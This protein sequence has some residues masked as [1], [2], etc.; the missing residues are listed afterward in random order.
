MSSNLDLLNNLQDCSPK[1]AW[2]SIFDFAW[3]T[4]SAEFPSPNVNAE[5][6]K[7]DKAI[8]EVDHFLTTAGWDLWDSYGSDAPSTSKE[9]PKWWKSNSSGRAILVLDALSLRESSW[10]LVG[11][12]KR[13]YKIHRSCATGAELPADTTPFAKALGFSQRSSLQ[14][15]QA[16]NAHKFS[17]AKTESVGIA[18]EDC[19]ELI[20]ADPDIFF[21]HQWPDDLIHEHGEPGSGRGLSTMVKETESHL[22][23]D[24]FW[25]FIERLSKGRRLVITADHGYA[26]SELFPDAERE[27]KEYLKATF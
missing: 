8:G 5:I 6:S 24:E 26:V 16:G 22:N 10:L 7:R 14:N 11:A 17:G 27:Q 12:K 15:N 21:W 1:E 4:C 2:R 13:G 19:A 23:S 18:W 3:T 25:G 9:L 20:G